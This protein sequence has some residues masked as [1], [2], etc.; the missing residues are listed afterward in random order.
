MLEV[1][2]IPLDGEPARP[3]AYQISIPRHPSQGQDDEVIDVAIAG[4]VLSCIVR[5]TSQLDAFLNNPDGQL[6]PLVPPAGVEQV[7]LIHRPTDTA[8]WLHPRH[9][10]PLHSVRAL[11]GDTYIYLL[12]R[13]PTTYTLRI[14]RFSPNVLIDCPDVTFLDLG[15]PLAEYEGPPLPD[16]GI[17][18]GS[19]DFQDV[20]LDPSSHL[21][22]LMLRSWYGEGQ[23]LRFPLRSGD[24]PSAAAPTVVR[25]EPD[26]HLPSN[27]HFSPRWLGRDHA[28]VFSD[29][30]D[31]SDENLLIR[32]SFSDLDSEGVSSYQIAGASG[33]TASGR[34]L[35]EDL[36]TEGSPL[37][38][39][40]TV[41]TE[42]R[43]LSVDEES[44]RIAVLVSNGE[45]LIFAS[46]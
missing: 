25:L 23:Y 29:D 38:R 16:S 27:A 5:D 30:D 20:H 2:D 43:A 21:S 26:R 22:V 40:T 42:A 15:E 28:I 11:F 7:Y 36:L 4:G 39:E 13:T 8:R 17:P 45:G 34:L 41:L 18:W 1:Y 44:G 24:Q 12:G 33:A 31:D 3:E 19:W 9:T 35:R 6:K 14:H 37:A 46:A 10:S 32:L